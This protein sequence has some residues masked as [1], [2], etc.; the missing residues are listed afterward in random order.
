M[1]LSLNET[2][3]QKLKREIMIFELK[4]G[5]IVSAQKLAVRYQVSRTPARE[6][7]IKLAQE[8]LIRVVAQSGSYVAGID[9]ERA[10]QEW[11]V[12]SALELS[13]AGQFVTLASNQ[14]IARMEAVQQELEELQSSKEKERAID[15]DHEFHDIIYD[16]CQ[17]PLAKEIIHTQMTHYD[18]IRYL[19]DCYMQLETKTSEEHRELI[20]ALKKK[21]CRLFETILRTHISRINQEKEEVMQRFPEYFI[22]VL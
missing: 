8:G 6:A 14:V 20:M 22:S 3:Y 17:Q 12:R 2:T 1:S 19:T 16:C 7:I 10:R 13:M 5:D 4:P 21:D 11:F 15:L 9:A 18:R